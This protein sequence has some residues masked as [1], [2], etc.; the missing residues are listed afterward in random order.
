MRLGRSHRLGELATLTRLKELFAMEEV[1][2]S[3]AALRSLDTQIFQLRTN[4]PEASLSEFA[5]HADKWY[6]WRQKELER[7]H[8][9]KAKLTAEL[10][11]AALLLGRAKAESEAVRKVIETA[12]KQDFRLAEQRRSYIS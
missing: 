11:S 7:L 12:T 2:K 4:R 8:L 6:L 1:A 9:K 3:S 10:R 5:R